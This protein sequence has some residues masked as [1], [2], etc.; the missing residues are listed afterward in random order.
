M[1]TL[2]S[3]V[4]VQVGDMIP[5]WNVRTGEMG[6]DVVVATRKGRCEGA[7]VVFITTED[8]TEEPWWMGPIEVMRSI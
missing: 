8:G 6:Y 3:P 1:I 7:N 5:Y 2:D 4:L